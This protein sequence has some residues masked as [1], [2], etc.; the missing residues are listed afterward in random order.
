MGYQFHLVW[1]ENGKVFY[2]IVLD[3]Q[4]H[5]VDLSVFRHFNAFISSGNEGVTTVTTVTT[6]TIS[7]QA[8]VVVLIMAFR[9]HAVSEANQQE[10]PLANADSRV[11]GAKSPSSTPVK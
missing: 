1:L 5:P 2:V 8:V 10:H 7:R 11:W 3:T 9:G 4:Y 6:Y